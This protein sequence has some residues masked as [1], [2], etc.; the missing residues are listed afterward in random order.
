MEIFEIQ[1]MALVRPLWEQLNQLHLARSDHF[2]DHFRT[3]TFEDRVRDLEKRDRV[4]IF[5]AGQRSAVSGYCI[6]SVEKGMGEVDSLFLVPD[7]RGQGLGAKLMS[8]AMDW[9]AAEGCA[10]IRISVAQGNEGAFGFYGQFGFK[11]RFTVL[12][13]VKG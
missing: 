5:G 12:E 8:A 10:K 2:K 9:L 13:Q 1:D 3:F 11:P 7:C 4:K 6:A